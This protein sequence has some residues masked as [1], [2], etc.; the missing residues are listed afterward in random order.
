MG[1]KYSRLMYSL[2]VRDYQGYQK[3]DLDSTHCQRCPKK[4]VVPTRNCS[5]LIPEFL[6]DHPKP[7]RHDF[8]YLEFHRASGGY[9]NH[10]I[11]IRPA[12][13]RLAHGEAMDI[14][15]SEILASLGET[16]LY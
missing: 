10:L 4:V 2:A 13:H 14:L 5:L 9:D 8:Q 11:P 7:L 16:S 1:F 15:P 6:D 12:E 3:G